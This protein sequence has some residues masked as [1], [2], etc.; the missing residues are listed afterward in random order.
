M[1]YCGNCGKKV[2]YINECE[3]CTLGK[4]F[5][6]FCRMIGGIIIALIIVGLIHAAMK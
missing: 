2:K 3:D 4:G 5:A 6:K 1:N